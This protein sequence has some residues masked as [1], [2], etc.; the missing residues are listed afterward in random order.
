M[1]FVEHHDLA[2]EVGE[3]LL[4]ARAN[5]VIVAIRSENVLRRGLT[6]ILL[7]LERINVASDTGWEWL[8][9]PG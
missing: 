8:M 2:E 7:E 9:I 6:T 1:N 4:P 3:E 5:C